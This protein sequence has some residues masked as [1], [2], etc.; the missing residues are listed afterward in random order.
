[1]SNW[2]KKRDEMHRKIERRSN[3]VAAVCVLLM[4]AMVF[5]CIKGQQIVENKSS[6]RDYKLMREM[7]KQR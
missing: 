3:I 7:Q 4:A 6:K 5:S 2:E 1:M